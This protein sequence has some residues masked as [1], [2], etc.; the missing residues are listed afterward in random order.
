MRSFRATP[1][2]VI[3]AKLQKI[4]SSISAH[5]GR[6][7]ALKFNTTVKMHEAGIRSHSI[8][9]FSD[10]NGQVTSLTVS[11]DGRWLASGSF[12]GRVC[13]WDVEERRSFC[14]LLQQDAP[15]VQ[16]KH[17]DSCFKNFFSDL[18]C[19]HDPRGSKSTD[20]FV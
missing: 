8:C 10:H 14:K 15:V 2:P 13:L 16:M 9:T 12:D 19:C 3:S 18:S 11:P 5:S 4:Y 17:A 7:W 1:G 20:I 6:I